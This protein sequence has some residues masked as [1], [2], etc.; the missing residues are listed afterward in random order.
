MTCKIV[1]VLIFIW[2]RVYYISPIV[3]FMIY[4]CNS[5]PVNCTFHPSRRFKNFM[6]ISNKLL[7]QSNITFHL[8]HHQTK[9]SSGHIISVE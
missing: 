7:N 9:S 3:T 2:A 5:K 6:F 4:Y 8:M 1:Y